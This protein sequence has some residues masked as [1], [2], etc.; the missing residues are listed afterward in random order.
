MVAVRGKPVAAEPEPSRRHLP[1]PE[2]VRAPALTETD[3]RTPGTGS[4]GWQRA[5]QPL[6][7][8]LG[9]AP[10]V[11]GAPDPPHLL[12]RL[13]VPQA[14]QGAIL[15]MQRTLGN[16]HTCRAIAQSRAADPDAEPTDAA[17]G[18][19]A[20]AL[21]VVPDAPRHTAPGP[22]PLPRETAQPTV[23][24]EP[25]P[26]PAVARRTEPSDGAATDLPARGPEPAAAEPDSALPP[27]C[28]VPPV[29]TP[30][31]PPPARPPTGRAPHR[32][33]VPALTTAGGAAE[34]L[35][36]V[37][38]SV[39]PGSAIRRQRPDRPVGPAPVATAA[40][41]GVVQRGLLDDVTDAV[42]DAAHGV[43]NK[44]ASAAGAAA[45]TISDVAGKAA[46]AVS[47]LI[48]AAVG[49]LKGAFTAVVGQI[50]GLWQ[51]VK[52]GATSLVDGAIKEATGFIGGIGA[53]FGAVGAAITG[54][55]AA[56]L[57]AAWAAVTGAA[58]AA[59]VGVRGIAARVTAAVDG[60]WSGLKGQA[61]GLI[62]GVRGRAE[63]LIGR[64][65]GPAQG[66]AR[67]L[68]SSIEGQL[69]STWRSIESG[70]KSVRDTAL[71][72][73]NEVVKRVE[74]AVATI[75]TSA[76]ASVI[77]TIEKVKGL[78]GLVKQLIANPNLLIDPIV[79]EVVA[80]LQGLPDKAKGEAQSK[81]QE[82]AS[83]GPGAAG[84]GAASA[85]PAPAPAGPAAAGPAAAM[86]S[87]A[88]GTATIRRRIQR[89]A[90]PAGTPRKSLSIGDV[91]SGLWDFIT[92]KLA[93][94]WANLGA[95]VKEMV[96]GVLLPSEIW[97][98]LKQ[99]WEQMT[100]DL[101]KRVSRF[102]HIR[103]DSWD[104]FWE[105]LR[106]FVS[107]LVDIPLIIWRTA[108]AMLGR[109]SVYI[110]LA[111]ILGGAV[112]GAIAAGT[113]GAVFGSVIPAA[114]TAG[115]GI[116][117]VAAGG[118]AGAQAGYAAAE[119]VGLVLLVSFAAAEQLSVVKAVNDLLWVPQT[120]EEQN[121]DFNQATDSVIAIGT[122]LL[123]M[124]IAF[125]GIAIAKRVWAAVKSFFGRFRPKPKVVEPGPAGPKPADS[126]PGQPKPG[127]PAGAPDRLVICRMC[128]PDLAVAKAVTA[129]P[130]VRKLV[131]SR[132]TVATI[133]RVLDCTAVPGVPKDLLEMRAKLTPEARQFLDS[134]LEKFFP[135]PANPTPDN[136]KAMR[137]FMEGTAK[138]GG[139]DL[140]AGLRK[141]MPKAPPSGP[142]FGAAVAELPRVRGAIEKLIAE[143]EDFAKANPDKETINRTATRLREQLDGPVADMENG[144]LEATPDQVKG[145]D[146]AIKG[147]QGE[148]DGAKSAPPGTKFG[149]VID[150]VEFDQVRSDGTLVQRKSIRALRKPSR[151]FDETVAQVKRTLEVA[152]RHPVGG[153]PRP[154]IVEFPEG[155]SADV[156]AELRAIEVN[157]RRATIVAKE[158]VVPPK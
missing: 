54:L 70:W 29:G 84:G 75:K 141:L 36:A 21:V 51:S 6:P 120:E 76:V 52:S 8:P 102:E 153:S 18:D 83:G 57:R 47:G 92:D 78:I 113:G 137:G 125:I 93:K 4:R 13:P 121:E 138:K 2:V 60:L 77:E 107:N 3:V 20:P 89:E 7:P 106:R 132:P 108:N 127:E 46:D 50:N 17:L 140:E 156:A 136:F 37:G 133:F 65:P 122:A 90:A 42:S 88:P 95:T 63:G 55:D 14:R 58:D 11:R 72:G 99:D 134:R 103:T 155:L 110:G 43:A 158:I 56:A 22:A 101:S 131:L 144:R 130:L 9:F 80:R 53:V 154:V 147:A 96:L 61:D 62:G 86:R 124:A 146:R 112:M 129:R 39:A 100:T 74:G 148:L 41:D 135:D 64:L 40:P 143:I 94:L 27:P 118:W 87:V 115:G 150:G 82:Q 19:H 149:E 24:P 81:A 33:P 142:P 10:F 104:G 128:D 145:V 44:V 67:S 38:R 49:E 15:Q 123:L 151:T 31:D 1:Q 139:G 97:K 48:D 23:D 45:D 59:L 34:P 119:S 12:L 5:A 28:P 116:V 16:C 117:G 91:V 25:I 85:G 71:K 111:I 152:E 30:P 126:D 79:Q 73:V 32:S 98:G 35:G 105:D 68:W 114:G 66:P 69:T 109:L 26:F 157:G